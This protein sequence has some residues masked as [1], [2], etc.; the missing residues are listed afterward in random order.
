[1]WIRIRANTDPIRIRI[2][3]P[4]YKAPDNSSWGCAAPQNSRYDQLL[5][6]LLPLHQAE[7]EEPPV[8]GEEDQLTLRGGVEGQAQHAA[9]LPQAD[10]VR[11]HAGLVGY[12]FSKSSVAYPDPPGSETFT[13]QG[14]DP[15]WPDMSDPDP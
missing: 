4:E 9:I 2:R 14:P 7:E 15:K 1:V 12:L 5:R 10:V 3:N 6:L 8:R 13:Y 11:L